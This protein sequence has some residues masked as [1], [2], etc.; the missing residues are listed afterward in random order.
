MAA[1][2]FDRTEIETAIARY[3]DIRMA[4]IAGTVPWTALSEVFTEDCVFID[5]VWGKHEG[6]DAVAQ[7]LHDSMVAL[8]DWDFPHLGQSI[9]GDRAYLHWANRL[10]GSQPDGSPWDCPGLSV[11]VY[12]GDGKFSYEEDLYSESQLA[13]VMAQSG[14]APPAN[15]VMPPAE[16]TWG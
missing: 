10:P 12:A 16:R 9:D 15:F 2:T 7:F 11:L 14:W 5:S 3:L 4:A 6:I 8:G 13:Q 1:A